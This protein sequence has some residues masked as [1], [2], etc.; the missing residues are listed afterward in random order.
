MSI[1]IFVGAYGRHAWP[2]LFN[3]SPSIAGE[4]SIAARS[5]PDAERLS[6]A[7]QLRYGLND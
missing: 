1:L 6:A 7:R 3:F 2:V 4:P 5:H